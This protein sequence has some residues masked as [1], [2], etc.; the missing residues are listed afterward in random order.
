MT[1][2]QV[3]KAFLNKYNIHDCS[4]TV[5]L[6]GGA[7]SMC[8][9]DALCEL[10]SE[11]NIDLTAAHVNHMLRGSE[12][13]ADE[14][15]AKKVCE[16]YGVP[17][18]A[19]RINVA[20]YA[21]KH[22]M[23]TEEAARFLRYRYLMSVCGDYLATAH[24]ENDN[25]ETV[26]LNVT[27][28]CGVHGLSGIPEKRGKIIRPLISVSRAEIENY[29]ACKNIKYVTDKTNFC[30]DYSRNR[31]R[32]TVLPELEKINSG[33]LAAISRLSTVAAAEDNFMD[34][35]A[36]KLI[37]L[38]AANGGYDARV[39]SGADAA[40]RY[41]AYSLLCKKF[42][43][44]NIAYNHLQAFDGILKNGGKINLPG[45][46]FAE[47]K[48]SVLTLYR[49]TAEQP[50]V[51]ELYLPFKQ[52]VMKIDGALIESKFISFEEFKK[53]KDV[54]SLSNIIM[55]DYDIIP[56]NIYIRFRKAGDRFML[57]GSGVTKSL[58]KLFNE[59]KVPIHMRDRTVI[60]E[61]DGEI[62]A[63]EGMGA[64]QKYGVNNNSANILAV[65]II[66]D[67]R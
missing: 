19:E 32:R 28:G 50:D 34:A 38:S 44:Q 51:S 2:Q 37:E 63:V 13:D 39:L 31:I 18:F 7:D 53:E 42:A 23:G 29:T 49:E 65:K 36:E 1:I 64:A 56:D 25:A 10:K 26:L 27:R 41:R 14:E 59:K 4:V 40:V 30:E 8:L 5:A 58:K 16:N 17:I 24:N 15:F 48:N 35:E 11:F 21:A 52:G 60:F 6:S 33:V 67:Q 20:E 43:K 46:F 3:I 47:V 55:L 57:C 45:N 61:G 9:L 66:R 22:G 12:A 62:V 54:N